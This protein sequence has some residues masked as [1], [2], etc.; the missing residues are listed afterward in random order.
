[1]ALD[2][3]TGVAAAPGGAAGDVGGRSRAVVGARAGG[4]S[5]RKLPALA[6]LPRDLRGARRPA[7]APPLDVR[8]PL[9]LE[10]GAALSSRRSALTTILASVA[11]VALVGLGSTAGCRTPTSITVSVVSDGTCADLKG[12]AIAASSPDS[13]EGAAPSASTDQCTTLPDGTARIGTLVVVPSGGATDELA[14]RVVAGVD[15]P[16]AECSAASGYQGCVVAR[17]VLHFA[18]HVELTLPIVLHLQCKGLACDAT[19]TCAPGGCRSATLPDGCDD[20]HCLSSLDAG[21]DAPKPDAGGDGVVDAPLPETGGCSAGSKNCSGACVQIDDPAFGCT[22][23]SCTTC[24]TDVR[25]TYTCVAGACKQAGCQTGYKLCGG[26]C[27]PADAAHGCGGATCDACTGLNGAPACTTGGACTMKCDPGYKLCGG[28]CVSVG[29][30]TYGCD[31][32]SCSAAACP[33]P[34]AGA[35]VVCV[36]SSCQIGACGPGTKAC[37]GN[38]VPTDPSHGCEDVTRCTACLKGQTCA[39][40]PPS[41]CQCVPDAASVTCSGKC[42]TVVGNCGQT[43]ACSTFCGKPTTCG[44][45]GV[46]NQCGCTVSTNPCDGVSC[47]TMLN[48]CALP[49]D[50]GCTGFNTCG[51]GG[52]P[53]KCGCTPTNPCATGACGTF[54]DGCGGKV[55]CSCTAPKTCGGGGVAAMCGCTPLDAPTECAANAMVC[56]TLPNGCGGTLSC[57]KCGLNQKCCNGGCI[58]SGSICNLAAL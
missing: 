20:E 19:S 10:V 12:V 37:G 47:G 8:Y 39:G 6:P 42:G 23:A 34:G 46:P 45:G 36:G 13:I 7:L 21:P 57:G 43:V 44:G 16:V 11:A 52:L 25:G 2:A 24:S 35:T 22:T 30:P 49:V 17:R 38:C 3:A 28:T 9:S 55:V 26:A 33:T 40:G 4:E 51:G 58:L 27:L 50:C 41:T 1:V 54:G 31:P 29:D 5:G 18:S 56:G 15:R 48:N 32:T 53:L 14:V